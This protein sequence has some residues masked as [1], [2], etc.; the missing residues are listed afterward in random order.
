MLLTFVM[1]SS[2]PGATPPP[3]AATAAATAT[4]LLDEA[5]LTR[6]RDRAA[7]YDDRNAFFTEDLEELRDAGY[8]AMMVPVE[9]G[10]AGTALASAVR[11]Q[12]RLATAAPATALAVN[13]HIL[14]TAVAA[15]LRARGDAS[16]EWV[17]RDAAAGEVF[18]FGISEPG[19]D[20]VLAD[21]FTRAERQ[22]D[23]GYR[24][25]G[26][27]IFG[28]LAPAWTRLGV[29]GRDD[30][31][32]DA[33]V[34]VHGFLSRD[35]GGY[36]IVEDWDTLGMRA[37]QSHTTVLEGARVAPERVS[38]VLPVGPGGD[39]FSF[40]I[41]AAFEL[42]VSSVYTGIGARAVQLATESALSRTSARLGGRSLAEDP[43]VR[44]ALAEAA[45]AQDG[46]LPPLLELA[47][48]VDAGVDHGR[49]WFPRLVGAKVRATRTAR[50]VVDAS[51]GIAG[52]GSYRSVSELARL[53]RDVA[54]GQ[55]H[56]SSER[57]ARRTVA[58]ALLGP[59]PDA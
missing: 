21:S 41:F 11:E 45:I 50:T 47:R 52:G 3:A 46:Q 23:G 36:R 56:P 30:G 6:I 49:A 1:A 25:F 18:A 35:T 57:A 8:L 17:L 38:R 5:L 13:M 14:W 53:Y 51:M 27:K 9:L 59:L 12:A 24:F 43:D 33:P 29:F 44:S 28:S 31:D 39:P 48:D 4:S 37:T 15:L 7:N 32:P 42:L 22:D 20:E 10:G 34:L 54:A 26:T 2:L 40:A 58:N 55:F 19:N 16:L